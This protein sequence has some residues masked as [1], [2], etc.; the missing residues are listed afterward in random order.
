MLNK[1]V[2]FSIALTW[3]VLITVLSLV[4]LGGL[5]QSIPIPNKDKYVHIIF[6]FCFTILWLAYWQKRK[7]DKRNEI[8][9]LL[10]A[11]GYGILMEVLQGTLTTYRSPDFLDVLANSTGAIGGLLFIRGF[12]KK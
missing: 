7:Y 3:T 5:G 8:K 4:S 11:I 1:K 12:L 2:F 10:C 6:Y 9:V